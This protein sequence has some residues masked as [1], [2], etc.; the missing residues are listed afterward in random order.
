MS[1]TRPLCYRGIELQGCAVPIAVPILAWASLEDLAVL[2][3]ASART[4]YEFQHDK[5]GKETN[6]MDMDKEAETL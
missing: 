5:S 3:N 4:S 6:T 1:I 2:N